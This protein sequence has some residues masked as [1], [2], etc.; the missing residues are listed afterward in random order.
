MDKHAKALLAGVFAGGLTIFALRGMRL[1]AIVAILAAVILIT[2]PKPVEKVQQD[3][4]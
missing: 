2:S 3:N 4:E 1:F